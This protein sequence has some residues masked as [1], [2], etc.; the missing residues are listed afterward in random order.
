MAEKIRILQLSPQFPLPADDGGKIGIF[1]ILKEFHNQ[2]CEVTFFTFND[3]SV[4]KEKIDEISRYCRLI[5][6]KH[7]IRN[8]PARILKSVASSRPLFMSKNI[9]SLIKKELARIACE[10]DFDVIHADHSSMTEHALLV[11]SLTKKPVGLRLHNIEWT[12]WQRYADILGPLNPKR[13]YIKRQAELIR[14]DECR[15]YGQMDVCFA[16][17]ATDR[18]RALGMA[19]GANVLVASAG[20]DVDLWKPGAGSPRNPAEMIIATNYNWV[21]NVDG[22]RWFIKSALPLIRD[23]IP[24]A[25]LTVIG[26]NMPAWI[27]EFRGNGVNPVG[28]V[29][30][31]KPYFEKAAIYISPLFVGGGIRIK[32][33]EAMAM[34]L[35]VVA[36]PVA[37]EGIEAGQ[38][39][40]LF[41]AR[42]EKEFARA[43]INLSNS[44]IDS[45]YLGSKARSLIEEKYT[46][47]ANVAIMVNEYRKLINL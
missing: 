5:L 2:G 4:D 13:A 17:T 44:A 10:N 33:L 41:V 18:Q 26:K 22:L 30:D 11:K 15:L 36:T 31:V 9:N 40:G 6:F 23:E 3:G 45:Q 14:R 12:I 8:T 47:K 42:N 28:Y 1:S 39:D 34:G 35:P 37:A 7:S 27:D 24:E 46:W 25:R 16:I 21:H 43:I 19:P 32:I 20:V 38:G 29:P